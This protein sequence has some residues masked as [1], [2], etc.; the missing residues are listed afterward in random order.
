MDNNNDWIDMPV[1]E[2]QY[3]QHPKRPAILNRRRWG[4]VL[5]LLGLA[6]LAAPAQA[7]HNPAH[8]TASVAAGGR[9]YDNWIRELAKRPPKAMHPLYPKPAGAKQTGKAVGPATSWRCVTCHGWDYQG[10]TGAFRTG[11]NFTGIKGIAR[12]AGAPEKDIVAVLSDDRH[13]YLEYFD[14]QAMHD[15]ALFV[16]KGQVRMRDY[17]NPDT[18]RA[19]SEPGSSAIM[20]STICVG[21]HG[22]DGAKMDTIPSMGDLTRADPWQAMHKMLNGHPGDEMPALR[23]FGTGTVLSMLAYMQTLPGDNMLISINRGG[24]LY[25]DWALEVG[26][27][28]PKDPHPAYPKGQSVAEGS[29]SWRCAECHGWDYKGAAGI[30]GLRKMAGAHPAPILDVLRDEVHGMDRFLKYRDL[31]DLASFVAH[32]QVEMNEF[33]EPR[34]KR[35]RG[36]ADADQEFFYA[37]CAICHGDEGKA[38][39]TM[40]AMGRVG[41]EDPWKALHKILHGH[42]GESMP[43]WQAALSRVRI[44]N[45]LAKIQTLPV[46]KR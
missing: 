26:K 35:A 11:R 1:P 42:P 29:S 23:V 44:K 28:Y 45:I 21:C 10:E 25:D 15:I 5:A 4:G 40:P 43:A 7:D 39:R 3:H 17:I 9:L 46:K 36:N 18:R 24:K 8:E 31:W 27:T 22:I 2:Q 38:I 41:Q 6:L 19:R 30:R 16:A 32:G 14:D 12:L 33:I 34:T 20:F 37:L 13:G